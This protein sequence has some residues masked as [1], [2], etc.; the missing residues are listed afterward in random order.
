MASTTRS[1][2]SLVT[3]T[4]SLIL[5]RKSTTYS[6]PR[7]SSVW[8]FWRPKPFTSV[9]VTPVTPT[10]DNASRTSSSL[11]GL[12]M[13]MTIFIAWA[14]CLRARRLQVVAAFVVQREVEAVGLRLGIHAQRGE[15]RHQVQRP[16]RHQ[17]APCAGDRHRQ[18]L[19]PDLAEHA[20]ARRIAD[21][22]QRLAGEH[23]GQQRADDAADAV[24]AEHVERIVVAQPALQARAGEQAE[25]ARGGADHQRAQRPAAAGSGRDRHQAGDCTGGNSQQ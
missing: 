19:R 22:A 24:H 21:A 23:A 2:W 1:T 15:L 6:A 4:S 12:M 13:A 16:G 11:K 14:S 17:A 18:R 5:G 7:Y 3:A 10:S 25:H 9:T 20:D 8:P